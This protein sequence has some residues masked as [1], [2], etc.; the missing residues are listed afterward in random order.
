[1]NI[2]EQLQAELNFNKIINKLSRELSNKSSVF[3][4]SDLA[5]NN[6]EKLRNEGFN[7]ETEG[8]WRNGGVYVSFKIKSQYE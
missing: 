8:A 6:I 3:I 2:A 1:M 7:V 4:D 5:Q